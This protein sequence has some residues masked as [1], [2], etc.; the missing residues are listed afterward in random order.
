MQRRYG[1]AELESPWSA[2]VDAWT[3]A[4]SFRALLRMALRELERR[5]LIDLERMLSRKAV[6]STL[7]G[8]PA[9]HVQDAL[10]AVDRIHAHLRKPSPDL[11]IVSAEL[12]ALLNFWTDGWEGDDGSP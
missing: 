2:S 10:R 7:S 6:R 12:D 3:I 1:I 8:A 4:G 11:A 5:R 9:Q